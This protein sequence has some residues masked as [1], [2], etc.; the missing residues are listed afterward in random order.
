MTT[1]DR[2]GQGF[3][4]NK[5]MADVWD[6]GARTNVYSEPRLVLTKARQGRGAH[7]HV[8][9][10]TEAHVW[11]TQGVHKLCKQKIRKGAHVSG[12]WRRGRPLGETTVPGQQSSQVISTILAHGTDGRWLVGRRKG[13]R[14]IYWFRTLGPPMSAPPTCTCPRHA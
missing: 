1:I 8:L 4:C 7:Y 3:A 9:E 14:G 12:K 11:A 5:S 6:V 10:S 13:A 2:E